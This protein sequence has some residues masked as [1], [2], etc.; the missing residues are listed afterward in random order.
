M[1]LSVAPENEAKIRDLVE[2]GRFESTDAFIEEA[3]RLLDRHNEEQ[4]KLHRLR[5][6]IDEG[7]EGPFTPFAPESWNADLAR[8]KERY[9]AEK[10]AK[11]QK[12][13]VD[14]AS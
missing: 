11:A 13:P 10:S 5:E 9:F 7:L 8:V 4:E 3:L 2:S 1:A 14:A 6:L 12:M